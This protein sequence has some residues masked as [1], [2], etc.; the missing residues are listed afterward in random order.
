MPLLVKIIS[1][2]IIHNNNNVGFHYIIMEWNL[3][4][5]DIIEKN[6]SIKD[7]LRGPFTSTF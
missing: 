5:M 2:G 6:L 4:I 7:T 3:S 1:T